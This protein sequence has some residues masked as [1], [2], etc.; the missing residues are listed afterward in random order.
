MGYLLAVKRPTSIILQLTLVP[1]SD[2]R[3]L[4]CQL[5]ELQRLGCCQ[6]EIGEEI[7]N[8]DARGHLV[9]VDCRG[10]AKSRKCWQVAD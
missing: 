10:N 2:H 9:H 8:R 7:D 4:Q 3:A 6:C 5:R 1:A